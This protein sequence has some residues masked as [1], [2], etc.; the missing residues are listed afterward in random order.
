MSEA[1]VR[2][3]QNVLANPSKYERRVPEKVEEIYVR[4]FSLKQFSELP[5]TKERAGEIYY[6]C[7]DLFQFKHC[8]NNVYAVY[9][10][11]K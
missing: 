4:V 3:I 9:Q 10:K 2:H 1:L 8:G 11:T 7:D 6:K 5:E